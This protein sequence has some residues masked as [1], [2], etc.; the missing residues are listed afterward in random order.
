MRYKNETVYTYRIDFKTFDDND[1]GFDMIEAHNTDEAIKI[2][3][4][5]YPINKYKITDVYRRISGSW[6][7]NGR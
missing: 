5:Y 1:W 2:F 6:D 3:R 4:S 7:T